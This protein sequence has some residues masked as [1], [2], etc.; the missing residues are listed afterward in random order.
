M[1]LAGQRARSVPNSSEFILLAK[2]FHGFSAR[3]TDKTLSSIVCSSFCCTLAIFNRSCPN[4]RGLQR[5]VRKVSRSTL[6]TLHTARSQLDTCFR[7]NTKA[8]CLLESMHIAVMVVVCNAIGFLQPAS[9]QCM[10]NKFQNAF[11]AC[12]Q[13]NFGETISIWITSTRPPFSAA[14]REVVQATSRLGH[15]SNTE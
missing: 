4:A 7:T 3:G 2:I 6:A 1:G 11:A 12:E 15:S 5:R 8:K 10:H 14:S 13:S 9:G